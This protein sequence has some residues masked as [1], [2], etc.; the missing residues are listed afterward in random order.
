MSV[1]DPGKVNVQ[2]YV[3]TTLEITTAGQVTGCIARPTRKCFL[4]A[5]LETQTQCLMAGSIP[6]ATVIS[7]ECKCNVNF[8]D[9]VAGTGVTC[10]A[11]SSP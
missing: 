8:Y 5:I 7:G 2:I 1:N 6:N 3:D 4:L 10:T 11:C 9:S